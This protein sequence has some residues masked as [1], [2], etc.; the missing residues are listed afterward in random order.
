MVLSDVCTVKT[1]KV[2]SDARVAAQPT[3]T[4]EQKVRAA[5]I[6]KD[7]FFSLVCIRIFFALLLLGDIVWGVYNAIKVTFCLILTTCFFY[8]KELCEQSLSRAWLG[9]KRSLVCALALF[10]SLFSTGFGIMIACTYFVMYDKEGI[11][12]VVPACLQDHFK[13]FFKGSSL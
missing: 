3:A 4:F 11:E 9:L 6:S 12:E 10:V 1:A 8:K 2:L 5:S 13:E 7:R